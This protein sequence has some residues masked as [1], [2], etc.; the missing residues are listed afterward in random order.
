ML[1]GISNCS[2]GRNINNK[3][4]IDSLKEV[5]NKNGIDT[6]FAKNIYLSDDFSFAIGKERGKDLMELYKN[7]DIEGIFDISGGDIANEVLDYLDYDYIRNSKKTFFGYSDLTTV[8]NAIYKVTGKASVLY[9]VRNVIKEK[10]KEQMENLKNFLLEDGVLLTDIDYTF[11]AGNYMSGIVVGGNIRCFLKLAG[12]KYFPDMKNKILFL[13]ALN[14][15]ETKLRTYF[16]QLS[17]MGVFDEISGILLGTFTEFER[18]KKNKTVYDLLKPYINDKVPVAK[19][20]E[21]GHS[22]DSKALRIGAFN[23]FCNIS[24]DRLLLKPLSPRY[25][26]STYEYASDTDNT[27]YMFFLPVESKKES[28]RYLVRMNKEWMAE[29]NTDFEFVILKDNIHVGGISLTYS[30]DRKTLEFGWILNKK[31]QGNKFAYEAAV[32]LL[33]FAKNVLGIT[34]F[35]AHCDADNVASYSLME[36]L[37]M[38][39]ISKTSGRMNRNAVKESYGYTYELSIK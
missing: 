29:K 20:N 27:K 6:V 35:I 39:K 37:G 4:E 18:D 33:E 34:H 31:Y 1:Y 26:D 19:T 21:V 17:Q 7:P 3:S 9:Q 24:T 5:L 12:T 14:G 36:K 28:L 22:S 10:G 16:A 15:N 8:I 38:K 2:N 13:E 32:S 11:L 25:V 23:R 30:E